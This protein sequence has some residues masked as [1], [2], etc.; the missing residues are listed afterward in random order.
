MKKQMTILYP[1]HTGLYINLTNRCPCAC[2]FCIRQKDESVYTNDSLWLEHEPT[3]EEVKTALCEQDLSLY[4]EFVFCGFG[5]PT[6]ALDVLLQTAEFIK[7][8]SDKPIRINTNGLGNLVNGKDIVP[9]LAKAVDVVSI[10]LNSSDEEIYKKNVRPK[11]NDAHKAMIDFAKAC[12]DS[13]LKVSMTTVSTTITKEDEE[14]CQKLCD[15]IGA[16]YRIREFI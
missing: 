13:G 9:L 10:S 7:T 11:F 3:F 4:S 14:N 12:V 15:S 5:E 2:T 1:V 6:E 8:K 16:K